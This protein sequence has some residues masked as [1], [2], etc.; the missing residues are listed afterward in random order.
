[1]PLEKLRAALA[2]QKSAEKSTQPIPLARAETLE[3]INIFE[4]NNLGKFE[5]IPD[6]AINNFQ[7]HQ[8]LLT[9]ASQ[10]S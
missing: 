6:N 10:K 3:N 4:I 8:A 1:M 7:T 9:Y 2:A 5:E